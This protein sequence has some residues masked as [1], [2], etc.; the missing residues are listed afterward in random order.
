MRRH[1]FNDTNRMPLDKDFLCI[2]ISRPADRR[3]TC[4]V[5]TSSTRTWN[6]V[7]AISS[8]AALI[9]VTALGFLRFDLELAGNADY[10]PFQVRRG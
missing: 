8:S 9:P 4:I 2:M 6:G 3:E 10:G 1:G 7:V 5:D